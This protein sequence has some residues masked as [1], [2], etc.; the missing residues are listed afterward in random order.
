MLGLSM[1]EDAA[2]AVLTRH[3]ALSL[4]AIN[5]PG[6][7]VVAGADE[8]IAALERELE[9]KGEAGRRL[10]TS[11]A[12]HSAMMDPILAPFTQLLA[13]VGL[14]APAIPYISNVTGTW[15]TADEATDPAYYARHLRS[16][17][18]FADGI[19]ALA[20]E[21]GRAL[22]EVGPGRTLA[23]LARAHDAVGRDRAVVT[24]LRHPSDS[25]DDLE[26]AL[27]ALGQLWLAGV[28]PDWDP[29][30][31]SAGRPWR[32][33]YAG[34]SRR[35]VPLPL[36][37]FQRERYWI[38]PDAD[39][40]KAPAGSPV[41]TKTPDVGKWFYAPSWQRAPALSVSAP[42]P[43]EFLV[44][45]SGSDLDAAF[46]AG[47][48]AATG[49]EPRVV[50]PGAGFA[51]IAEGFTV[52]PGNVADYE[53][54]FA[55][56][57]AEKSLPRAVAH[58]WS[59]CPACDFDAA[60][61]RGFESLI[62]L[63][64]GWARQGEGAALDV[65]A[66][67]SGLFDLTGGE[68]TRPEAATILGAMRVV[69]QELP[70]V[71]VRLVDLPAQTA[72]LAQPL[73]AEA[74]ASN[75]AAVV[76]LR[77][78]ARWQQVFVPLP[79]PA[80]SPMAEVGAYLVTGG[81][82]RIG[83]T[84]AEH[85]ARSSTRAS[86]VLIDR[87]AL[88][89]REEWP[90][91]LGDGEPDEDPAAGPAAALRARIRR[92]LAMELEGA[93]VIALQADV[94]DAGAM[95]RVVAEAEAR[96]GSLRGV[97]HAAGTVGAAAI[98]SVAETDAATRAAQFGP[99]VHGALALADALEGRQPDFVLLMSSLSTT[100][101]GLGFSAYAAAN[102]FMDA[103]A[104]AQSAK[105]LPW[106]SAAWD[107]WAFREEQAMGRAASAAQAFAIKPEEGTQ[108]FDRLLS[109][110]PQGNVLVSTGDLHLRLN[111]PKPA[112][113]DEGKAQAETG[114]EISS[115]GGKHARPKLRVAYV[116]PADEI[117]A[118]MAADW[119]RILGI[120]PIGAHDD[121]FELGGHSL[122]A[123]QLVSRLRDAY[124][125]ELPLRNL[126]ETP[127]I[128]GLAAL[129]RA[130]QAAPAGA[131]PAAITPRDHNGH[132]PL[133]FGQ[134]R[135]WFLDQ[136]SPGSP[137]Y[138]NFAALRLR[139]TGAAL[140]RARLERALNAVVA[141]HDALR[142]VFGEADGKPTQSIQPALAL[143]VPEI[144]L[145]DTPAT[146]RDARV[147][148]LALEEARA[149]FDLGR[150]PLL[151]ATLVRTAEDEHVLF[152]TMHH[153]VSDGWSVGVLIREVVAA[154]EQ[155]ADALAPLPIQYA[156]FAAWQRE[157]LS[158]AAREEQLAYWR[159]RLTPEP[160]PLE[161]ATDRPRPPVQTANGA[162]RWFSIAPETYRGLDAL[163]RQEGATLF[164]A[165]LAGFQTLLSRYTGQ[166]DI[167][168]GTPVANRD[169][170]ETAN[171]IGFLLNTLALR[172]DL[173]ED[174]D[175]QP[176]TFRQALARAREVALGAFGRQDVPFEMLVEALQPAR[177]MSRSPFFQV[178]FDLQAA[179]LAGLELAGIQVEPLRIDGGA[180]KFD[181]ALQ[182]EYGPETL[183]GYL[184]YNTDLFDAE[185]IDAMIG[186]FG[187]L[188]AAA[189]AD[190]DAA[191]SALPLMS[192]EEERAALYA[193][194]QTPAELRDTARG[195]TVVD[196]FEAQ[197]LARGDQPAVV[198]AD[199]SGAVWT[200]AQL[201]A[202]ANQLAHCLRARGAGRDDIVA[203]VLHRN[204]DMVAALWACLKAGAGFLPIDPAN[205]LDR[206]MFML[207]DSAAV[208]VVADAATGL[209]SA[210]GQ[211]G[212][213][214][215]RLGADTGGDNRANLGLG[216]RGSDLAYVIYTSGSTGQPK[217]VLIEHGGLAQH[218]VDVAP[219]FGL[220][221]GDRILQFA[222]YTFDQGLEQ[223]FTA[224]TVGGTLVLRGDDIWPPADFP[225]V[226]RDYGLN[227]I[228]LPPV[229]W[230]QVLREWTAAAGNE[231]DIPT[232]QVK[233]IISGGD[234]LTPESLRLWQQTPVASAR[235]IN[236]YG[237][238]ETT[239]TACAFDTP[240]DWHARM[241]RPVPIGLPLPNRV[242]YVVDQHGA[243]APIG[244]PGE[245]WLGG[246]GVARGYLRRDALTAEK[247]IANPFTKDERWKIEDDT[248]ASDLQSSILNLAPRL[249]RT[250][251][252]VRLRRDGALEFMGRIDDQVK[253]RGF[254]IELGEIEAALR[255]H[256]AVADAVVVARDDSAAGGEKRL[257][258]FVVA[259]MGGADPLVARS[260]R[261]FVAEHLPP[262]MVP[263][264]FAPLDALPLTPSGK[265]DRNALKAAP[266]PDFDLEQS[267][268]AYI[269]PRTP[270][271]EE[272][273]AIWAD[274]LGSVSRSGAPR[275]G[276]NDNFFDLGG[277]SLLAT[278]IVS[279]L[280]ARYPVDLPLRRLFEA[281]TV[282]GLAA[283]IEEALLSQQT[284]DELAALLAELDDL[285]GE[286]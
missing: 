65:L 222:A 4:A 58:L 107:G 266:L 24:S 134:E 125:V 94:A 48:A 97:I 145:R 49:V 260:L 270:L 192:P 84:L 69:G 90:S 193:W 239:I 75:P 211:D 232:G 150:G 250:G 190:P 203:L 128:A 80:P 118:A 153:I 183:S 45:T 120:A 246:A 99:K 7:V 60:Q 103:F 29:A 63:A 81:L 115:T 181:L 67:T 98:K 271:E 255:E 137:L 88:P 228:N 199:G 20:A 152:F 282:A 47:L 133:S 210:L 73:V 72:G 39:W 106:L 135:L 41:A 274:V 204:L 176:P 280:R 179:P 11:H 184:N 111:P 91:L 194:N 236:A 147:R 273:A 28:V 166:T 187:N 116:E 43:R 52:R 213:R 114:R 119:E 180:A 83:L 188:L 275:I 233:T 170:A 161:L 9:A 55:A 22:L 177:D 143:T 174:A 216:I 71:A 93:E 100:L 76:A 70:Q 25:T 218:I 141:R 165:L 248:A 185:T 268:E 37:P 238:T 156:D 198:L 200:Y 68:S 214:L 35:R 202:R 36:Y 40:D 247:F 78:R 197:V 126:F 95:R 108:V 62:A 26:F 276:V 136:L 86:L 221:P 131:G 57:K 87:S 178:M 201:N 220:A 175:E 191:I 64:Q 269:A 249:Y 50:A 6:M 240:P 110:V 102:A 61:S 130:A 164:M 32:A 112:K 285:E 277:H 92:I 245:L 167:V 264:A 122:L 155:G 139:S 46:V 286:F 105:G 85:I 227:A 56:L 173:G 278:Q 17:V 261:A 121:F 77:G 151:R 168:V 205:P 162:N 243:P 140:D 172:T 146:E 252:R 254:R 15:I 230:S 267:G 241:G 89:P 237:P 82:G 142:A 148:Q 96:F 138:N 171:L 209:E 262:Y 234:V 113:R 229:Y 124:Q 157:W 129:I 217:G 265:V 251:D 195:R 272:I 59:A 104:L 109:I 257:V 31:E 281:P 284:E 224:H 16:A 149:P 279:R 189:V 117:E 206:T 132:P 144:D 123:T 79:A 27:A 127:T 54:L 14:S 212:P 259:A 12:F 226:I 258:A 38:E 21:P 256:L 30:D 242:A 158:G 51:A 182:L 283:L 5:A 253:I 154:Y 10:R 2:R 3:P 13:G 244:V 163:A 160:E 8:A 219:R 34:E 223:V 66:V 33:F 1:S 169:R 196:L 159:E 231:I 19:A 263:A 225:A 23:S 215:I 44:F 18:R 42:A 235:L 208:A 74:L 186:H 53:R 207:R 101:G